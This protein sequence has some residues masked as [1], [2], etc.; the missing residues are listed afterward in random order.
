MTDY[1]K[2]YESAMVGIS[3]LQ[4]ELDQVKTEN[5]RL[6]LEKI[7]WQSEK[8]RQMAVIAQAVGQANTTSN[9]YLE[10]NRKLKEE[11]RRL[12]DVNDSLQ[13]QLDAD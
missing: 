12:K 3:A 9:G 1:Q 7:Q 11:I 8:D 4:R 13:A 2:R 5:A 6:L 10:E